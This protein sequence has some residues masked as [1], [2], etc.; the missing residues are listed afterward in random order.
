MIYYGTI[1][2]SC[3]WANLKF[4]QTPEFLPVTLAL[5]TREAHVRNL[6]V[7]RGSHQMPHVA[8]LGWRVQILLDMESWIIGSAQQKAIG[9][10]HYPQRV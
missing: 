1:N 8:E 6:L 9:M 2:P 4:M 10:S 5:R 3:T 7:P